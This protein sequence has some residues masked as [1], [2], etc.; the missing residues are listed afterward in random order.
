MSYLKYEVHYYMNMINFSCSSSILDMQ[1]QQNVQQLL[2]N[3]VGCFAA[4]VFHPFLCDI[5]IHFLVSCIAFY[6][7][8]SHDLVANTGLFI[9]RNIA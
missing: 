5:Y 3:N 1:K 6:R 7:G 2:C 9:Y 4:L 8:N